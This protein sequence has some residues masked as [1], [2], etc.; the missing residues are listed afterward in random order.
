MF[1]VALPLT[2]LALPHERLQLIHHGRRVA[3]FPG[4]VDGLLRWL[5]RLPSLLLMS[6]AS[7]ALVLMVIAVVGSSRGRII[8]CRVSESWLLLLLSRLRV[9]V[10]DR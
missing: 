6:S 3:L 9:H 5:C 10:R 4:Y 1:L 2:S 8:A 7:P